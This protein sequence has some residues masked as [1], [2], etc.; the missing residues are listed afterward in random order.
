[1]SQSQVS[2]IIQEVQAPL[3]RNPVREGGSG[4][5]YSGRVY[6]NQFNQLAS[7]TCGGISVTLDQVGDQYPGPMISSNSLRPDDT[8]KRIPPTQ[9]ANYIQTK[10]NDGTIPGMLNNFDEQMKADLAFYTAAQAEYCFYEARYKVALDKFLDM[11]SQQ[12]GADPSA[13]DYLNNAVIPLNQRLNGL[14]EIMNFVAND[15][16]TKVNNR[17]PNINSANTE[18]NAKIEVLRG[19]QIALTAS[20]ARTR[21]QEEMVR[22]SAEK[23]HAMNIQI[24]FFVA[25][26]VVALGT[27]LT[28]YKNTRPGGGA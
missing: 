5:H 20:N 22:Y 19:Q 25:L 17:S 2:E 21:T 1:M 9:L 14:L 10:I 8:T 18:L 28:V 6:T 7:D 12:G 27:I 4:L 15:R 11:V 3:Q 16:A 13:T 23:S 24:I 26:N